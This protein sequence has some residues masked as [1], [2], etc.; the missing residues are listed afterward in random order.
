MGARIFHCSAGDTIGEVMA[1]AKQSAYFT[2]PELRDEHQVKTIKRALGKI[3]GVLSVSANIYS[4]QV[5]VDYDG[6]G[7]DVRKIGDRLRDL[8]MDARLSGSRGHA[9]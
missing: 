9:M 6:S 3:P 7:A 8:G 5:A 2:V 4:N 1:V